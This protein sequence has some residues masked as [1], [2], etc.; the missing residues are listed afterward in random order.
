V[1]LHVFRHV[2]AQQFDAERGGELLGDFRLAD[3]GGARE[4]VGADRLLRFAQPARASLIADDSAV[5][6]VSWP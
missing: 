3:A 6:A 1:A 4:Q 5:I 2:E